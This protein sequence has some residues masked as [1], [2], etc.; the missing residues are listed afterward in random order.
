MKCEIDQQP[1]TEFDTLISMQ[2]RN[3]G[4]TLRHESYEQKANQAEES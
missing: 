1:F 2:K 4:K 3:I